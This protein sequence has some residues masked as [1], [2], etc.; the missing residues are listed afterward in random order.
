[1]TIKP[2]DMREIM[3]L[4]EGSSFDELVLET[5]G[6]KLTLRRGGTGART[7]PS[8]AV[9]EAAP[10]PTPAIAKGASPAA[11]PSTDPGLGDVVA[12]L[13]GDFYRAPK[14]GAEPFVEVG[15]AVEPDTVIGIIEV[16]KLMNSIRAGV[17]GV[18]EEICAPNGKLVEYGQVLLRVRTGA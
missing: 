11:P 9:V 5:G 13:L 6:Q 14:P 4:L 1:M 7:E 18:V 8:P 10:A 17:K 12:P 3:A 16:M 15:Q 2:E